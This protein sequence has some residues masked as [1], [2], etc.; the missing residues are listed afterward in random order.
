MAAAPATA[1][2]AV[3]DAA[4]HHAVE[5]VAGHATHAAP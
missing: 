5:A 2:A 4:I 1:G 3:V